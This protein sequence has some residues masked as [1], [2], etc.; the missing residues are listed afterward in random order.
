MIVYYCGDCVL[1]WW[2]CIIVV[3]VYYCCDCVLLWLL[4]IIVMIVCYSRIRGK[5]AKNDNCNSPTTALHHHHRATARVQTPCSMSLSPITTNSDMSS[6]T[7]MQPIASVRADKCWQVFKSNYN[8]S[9]WLAPH[10]YS[11]P[12]TQTR[13][14]CP[15][16]GSDVT[17]RQVNQILEF[18]GNFPA[19]LTAE[20]NALWCLESQNTVASQFSVA[21]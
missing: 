19:E 14:Q 20:G 2:L 10:L 3:I 9:F 15:N 17:A 11:A 5:S 16:I 7:L 18:S 6:P 1:L 8:W 12:L 4:C 21:S 13:Y